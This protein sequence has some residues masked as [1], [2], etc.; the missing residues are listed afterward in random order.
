MKNIKVVAAII[1]TK[2][3][4]IYCSQ[5]GYGEFKDGWEFPGGKIEL[6]ETPKQAL[7]REIEEEFNTEIV[8]DKYL[9]TVKY[10]Y[11]NFFLNMRCYIV[12][13][14]KGK[15]EMV[16]AEAAK[17]VSKDEL[18]S[19]DFLPADKLIMPSLKAYLE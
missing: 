16:Q 7:K 1:I 10:Q 4:K 17:I 8:I 18:D 3:N 14:K 5:R 19:V 12:H 6:G 11:P 15:L 13:V 2:D 9:T